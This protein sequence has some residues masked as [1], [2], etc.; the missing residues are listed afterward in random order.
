MLVSSNMM[1]SELI[2]ARDA[3]TKWILKIN[4][5]LF[6][7]LAWELTKK[8]GLA[9]ATF[10]IAVEKNIVRGKLVISPNQNFQ[11]IRFLIGGDYLNRTFMVTAS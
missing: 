11:S 2:S 1:L 5:R 3:R 8:G 9:A 6:H 7:G 4:E 10:F